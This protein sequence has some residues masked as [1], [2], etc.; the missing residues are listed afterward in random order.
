MHDYCGVYDL[1]NAAILRVYT[2]KDIDDD[3]LNDES[4][5][6][7]KL[8]KLS[9]D[10]DSYMDVMLT[11]EQ[12]IQALSRTKHMKV[13]IMQRGV[14]AMKKHIEPYTVTYLQEF[15]NLWVAI[16]ENLTFRDEVKETETS[17]IIDKMIVKT[18]DMD[19]I[20]N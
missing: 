19:M 1:N 17:L 5:S 2:T 3:I 15:F 8:R 10:N 6:M 16:W 11:N 4:I 7:K 20:R 9:F 13:E 12:G 14:E 18:P